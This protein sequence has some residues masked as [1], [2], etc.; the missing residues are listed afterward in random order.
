MKC[1]IAAR[2]ATIAAPLLLFAPQALAQQSTSGAASLDSLLNTQIS[3]ASK[4][5]QKT[6]QAP[7][8]VTIGAVRHLRLPGVYRGL[9]HD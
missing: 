7:A 8:S 4:Y 6:A 1:S 2:A 9:I 3:A 5:T